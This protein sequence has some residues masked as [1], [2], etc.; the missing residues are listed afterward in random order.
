MI[1]ALSERLDYPIF[2]KSD[3]E[4]IADRIANV[5]VNFI[6]MSTRHYSIRINLER[7]KPAIPISAGK[8]SYFLRVRVVSLMVF[9]DKIEFSNR[10]NFSVRKLNLAIKAYAKRNSTTDKH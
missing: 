5:P 7:I 9:T 8:R 10:G 2:R 1:T 4:A 3:Y 6:Y